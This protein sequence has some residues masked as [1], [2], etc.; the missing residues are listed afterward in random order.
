MQFMAQLFYVNY[1][2]ETFLVNAESR[3][4]A[5]AAMKKVA[6]S[7]GGQLDAGW[8]GT[9]GTGVAVAPFAHTPQALRKFRLVNVTV[10][11]P[12]R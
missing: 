1:Q 7:R 12:V 3:T 8:P 5:S 6:A 4:A 9:Y 11:R 2:P 10:N